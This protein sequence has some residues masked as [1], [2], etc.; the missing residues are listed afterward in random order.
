[1]HVARVALGGG[2]GGNVPILGGKFPFFLYF[3]SFPFVFERAISIIE[4][5]PPPLPP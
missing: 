4:G 2:G 1:M 3:A 5:E